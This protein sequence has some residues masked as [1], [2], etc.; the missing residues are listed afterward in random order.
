MRLK[1][2]DSPTD[3][4]ECL[5]HTDEVRGYHYPTAGPGE[6]IFYGCFQGEIALV[7]SGGDK[8]FLH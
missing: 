3:L 7:D 5:G 8:C 2:F 1:V 6:T 4:D